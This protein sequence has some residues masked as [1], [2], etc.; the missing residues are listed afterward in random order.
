MTSKELHEQKI[1][2]ARM[3]LNKLEDEW[4]VLFRKEHGE[5]IGAKAT[6]DTCAYSCVEYISDHNECMG[7]MCTCC[8]DWCVRWHPENEVSAFLRMYY[9]YDSHKFMDLQR[10]FGSDFIEDCDKPEKAEIVMKMLKLIAEFD[11]KHRDL[12][13]DYED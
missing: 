3:E 10:V 12:S 9:H 13:D 7:G 8:N 1:I 5:L 4:C 11:D 2:P 6:C